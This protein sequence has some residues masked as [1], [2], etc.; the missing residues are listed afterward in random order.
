MSFPSGRTE[1]LNRVRQV[2]TPWNLK[3]IFKWTKAK[4]PMII[5]SHSDDFRWF[6]PEENLD[7]WDNIIKIFNKYQ[8][9]D[10]TNKEFVGI[11]ISKDKS[12]NYYMDQYRMIDAINIIPQHCP[13]T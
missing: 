2:N 6:G 5:I 8:V 7:V 10:A 4:K 3:L 12:F 13:T 11:R 1:L 9:T